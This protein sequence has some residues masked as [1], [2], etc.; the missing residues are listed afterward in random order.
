MMAKQKLSSRL[1]E[2]LDETTH[3]EPL[4]YVEPDEPPTDEDL[5]GRRDALYRFWAD[6]NAMIPDREY[7]SPPIFK[8]RRCGAGVEDRFTH[9]RWHLSN[10]EQAARTIVMHETVT[11]LWGGQDGQVS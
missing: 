11:A 4:D 6:L 1:T 8:C 3:Y 9:Y 7:W 5:S 10:V 2:I